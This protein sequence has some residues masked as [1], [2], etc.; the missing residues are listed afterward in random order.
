MV[1]ISGKLLTEFNI[2][3]PRGKGKN[4]NKIA[5][6]NE[7]PKWHWSAINKV[8][9]EYKDIIKQW[10]LFEWKEEPLKDMT[11]VFKLYRHNHKILDSDN[12]GFIIKWTIDAIKESGWLVDDDQITY[13]VLP[14][15]HNSELIESTIKVQCYKD[16]Q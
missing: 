15:T 9:T 8:K 1:S 4:K 6:L 12:I 11:I 5:S 2:P 7:L 14:S 13:L 3:L 10:Y 16:L